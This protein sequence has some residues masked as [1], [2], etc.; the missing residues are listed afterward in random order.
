MKRSYTMLAALVLA[1][2]PAAPA[3]AGWKLLSQGAA[4]KVGKSTLTVTPSRHWNRNS[5]RPVPKGEVW[6]IDGPLLNELYFVSG[7][8]PGETLYR[9]VN[10][11]ERPLPQFRATMQLTD[12]PELFESSN[13][14]ALQTPLFRITTT[15]PVRFAGRDGVKFTYE[16]SV[17]GSSLARK[18]VATATIANGQLHLISFTAP[19]LYYFDRD[20]AAAE[21]VMASATL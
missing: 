9:D 16:Y 10:R 20:R 13:R 5:A 4:A 15:E 14:L 19:A 1:S 17:A 12:I 11:K 8:V 21:A 6:T 7:L 2:L 3:V 18:G